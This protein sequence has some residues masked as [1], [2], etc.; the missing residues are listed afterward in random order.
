MFSFAVKTLQ[1]FTGCC[2]D[3]CQR[4]EGSKLKSELERTDAALLEAA[5]AEA[6]L[7]AALLEAAR[8]EA[9]L[10]LNQMTT[11]KERAARAIRQ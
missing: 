2:S 9:A 1:G 6:A 8:A 7:E 4:F 11:T 3:L 10:K 5:L